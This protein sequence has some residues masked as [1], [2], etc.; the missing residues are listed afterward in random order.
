MCG[1]SVLTRGAGFS[2]FK[3]LALPITL[4]K[5]ASCSWILELFVRILLAFFSLCTLFLVQVIHMPS[6]VQ[7][8]GS[9][10]LFFVTNHVI[11]IV[12]ISGRNDL[13]SAAYWMICCPTQFISVYLPLPRGFHASLAYFRNS[14]AY[15]KWNHLLT[16][17]CLLRWIQDCS[18]NLIT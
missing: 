2:S 15:Q 5:T 13:F 7:K 14:I 6:P 12:V 11:S 9:C 3:P 16:C 18:K 1:K 10:W 8:L 4:D 17:S